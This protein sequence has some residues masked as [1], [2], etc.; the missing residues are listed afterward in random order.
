MNAFFMLLFMVFLSWNSFADQEIGPIDNQS[1]IKSAAERAFA[2]HHSSKNKTLYSRPSRVEQQNLSLVQKIEGKAHTISNSFGDFKVSS[3]NFVGSIK[4]LFNNVW[5]TLTGDKNL[6]P[7]ANGLFYV[8]LTG[9]KYPEVSWIVDGVG[10]TDGTIVQYEFDFGDGTVQ[11]IPAAHIDSSKAISHVYLATGTYNTSVKVFDNDGAFSTFYSSI[12]V[13]HS[14]QLPVPKFTLQNNQVPDFLKVDFSSQATDDSGII[15]YTWRFGDGSADAIGANLTSTSRTYSSP[16]LYNVSFVVRD[17]HRGQVTA[18]TQAYVGQHQP[19]GGMYPIPLVYSDGMSGVAPL[20]VQ[21]DG[22]KSFDIGGS[23]SSYEWNFGDYTSPQNASYK[24]Q[25]KFTYSQPGSYYGSL[26]VTDNGGRTN[27]RYFTVYVMSSSGG[28]ASPEVLAYPTGLRTYW[29]D[30]DYFS[31]HAP[32]PTYYQVWNFG[33]GTPLFRG[34]YPT[35][36]YTTDGVYTVTLHLYDVRGGVHQIQKNITVTSD[37]SAPT[38]YFLSSHNNTSVNTSVD[39]FTSNTSLVNPSTIASWDFGD[40]TRLSGLHKDLLNVSHIY[41]NKGFYP[42]TLVVTD[43]FGKTASHS[44]FV[45]IQSAQWPI[46]AKIDLSNVIGKIPLPMRFDAKGSSSSEGAITK[47]NWAVYSPTGSQ[48]NQNAVWTSVY[49]VGG[50]HY[51]DLFIEDQAGN[52]GYSNV[53]FSALDPAQVPPTNNAPIAN[54]QMNY[55]FDDYVSNLYVSGHSSY[56]TDGDRIVSY[57]WIFDSSPASSEPGFNKTFSDSDTHQLALRVTDRWGAVGEQKVGFKYPIVNFHQSLAQPVANMPVDFLANDETM[58]LH[59]AQISSVEWNFG[60]G[61][62]VAAGQIVSHTFLSAGIFQVTM[63][64]QDNAQRRY[65]RV[66]FVTV[67]EP[68]TPEATITIRDA[69]EIVTGGTGTPFVLTE[70]N[71]VEVN[72]DLDESVTQ[73]P[74]K[75]VNWDFGDGSTG[76]GLRPNYVY[77]RPGTYTV[78]VVAVNYQNLTASSSALVTVG[79]EAPCANVDGYFDCLKIVNTDGNIFGLSQTTWLITHDKNPSLVWLPDENENELR[80]LLQ[81]KGDDSAA[82][83]DITSAVLRNGSNLEISRNTLNT[84]NIDFTASYDLL[85]SGFLSDDTHFSGGLTDLHFGLGTMTIQLNENDVNLVVSS[86][87][88]YRKFIQTGNSLSY[89]L[90]DLPAGPYSIKAEKAARRDIFSSTIVDQNIVNV[91]V[92]ISLA[93][94]DKKNIPDHVVVKNLESKL[95]VKNLSSIGWPSDPDCSPNLSPFPAAIEGERPGHSIALANFGSSATGMEFI[96]VPLHMA[97]KDTVT[98]RCSVA[99][100]VNNY[101]H[102]KESLYYRRHK[103]PY[104]PVSSSWPQIDAIV[105]SQLKNEIVLKWS[106][107]D[108]IEREVLGDIFRTSVKEIMVNENLELNDITYRHG[109]MNRSDLFMWG[110]SFQLKFKIPPLIGLPKL[111]LSL[112]VPGHNVG[113]EHYELFKVNCY[114]ELQKTPVPTITAIAG[115]PGGSPHSAEYNGKQFLLDKFFPVGIDSDLTNPSGLFRLSDIFKARLRVHI[116]SGSYAPH[117]I[118]RVKIRVKSEGNVIGNHVYMLSPQDRSPVASDGKSFSALLMINAA[119]FESIIAGGA[120]GPKLTFEFLPLGGA[121]PEALVRAKEIV[122]ITP[123]YNAKEVATTGW[124]QGGICDGGFYNVERVSA[125]ATNSFLRRMMD[126]HSLLYKTRCNDM[127]LP[128]GGTFS[129][130]VAKHSGR[131][132]RRGVAADIRYFHYDV[133]TQDAYTK[134]FNWRIE[135]VNA[136]LQLSAWAKNVSENQGLRE[137]FRQA[138]LLASTVYS[139]CDINTLTHEK[140]LLLCQ[141]NRHPEMVAKCEAEN[142]GFY[143]KVLRYSEWAM[144]TYEGLR[145]I[146][147]Q[148]YNYIIS[149]GIWRPV[150]VNNSR[151]EWQRMALEQGLWPDGTKIYQTG[152]PPHVGIGVSRHFCFE[153]GIVGANCRS[154]NVEQNF[155]YEN[156]HYDHIHLE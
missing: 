15:R 108:G 150:L 19:S 28:T 21:F 138:C 117:V 149:D 128:W 115:E 26:K 132:H 121:V 54:I 133:T 34:A 39:F 69:A 45:N 125:Y 78:N 5:G 57:D 72:F 131:G 12:N 56:D 112:K 119:D 88:G 36:T 83:I 16:G 156:N 8:Y 52:T 75:T 106:I 65:T 62:P 61:T 42:V 86:A 70:K 95:E 58:T 64:A 111:N 35:H 55:Y 107:Q 134:N 105:K 23:V 124:G 79:T 118:D 6:P 10:D 129:T 48:Y 4:R 152:R 92:D 11:L 18:S 144:A 74:W 84:L 24:S 49:P 80:V 154:V 51:V 89:T 40:G 30:S 38:A 100:G 50:E 97:P 82:T 46:H 20:T 123:L 27:T 140:I 96:R 13:T 33:D 85:V 147:E 109:V 2:A 141:S 3:Y 81:P 155:R 146:R 135:D 103:W 53:V 29:F 116:N 77:R 66:K 71:P 126:A 98:I 93:T 148:F 47:Y 113:G 142:P 31:L 94:I 1:E 102:Y 22:L 14:N 68:A 37:Q 136:Y 60:D 59:G 67:V 73:T 7:Y 90:T 25:P 63:T 143:S 104:C 99:A 76:F 139:E 137:D 32:V 110:P 101:S 120:L 153:G 41:T 44:R 151:K 43:A 130:S 87:K 122:G 114:A 145:S 127:S 17:S 91:Y 9:G